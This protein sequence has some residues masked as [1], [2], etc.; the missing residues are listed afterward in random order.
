MCMNF[1]FKDSVFLLNFFRERIKITNMKQ[2]LDIAFLDVDTQYDFM[3][4]RG[5]LYVPDSEKIVGNIEKLLAFARKNGLPIFGSVDAHNPDDP[6]ME[7]VGGPFPLHC[8]KGDKGQE[9]ISASAPLN[10]LWVENRKYTA[11]E[12]ESIFSHQG[13]IYF[14]KQ[15]FNLFDNPNAR[16][17]LDR[18]KLFVVF[19]VATD[20]CVKAAVLGLLEMGKTVYVVKDAI[21]PVAPESGEEAIKE[22]KK[23]GAKLIK[24]DEVHSILR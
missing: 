21:K 12:L 15:S 18:F 1:P 6:E 10:P 7:T 22:M 11:D 17:V 2:D 5:N 14:E 19:G 8:I 23:K 16:I 3:D 24:A 9:K 13:E 20:Y 4:P